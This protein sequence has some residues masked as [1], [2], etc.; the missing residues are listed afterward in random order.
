VA[1]GEQ[2]R[3]LRLAGAG[4][5]LGEVVERD[6]ERLQLRGAFTG[7]GSGS[8]PAAR[9]RLAAA[10]RATGRTIRRARKKAAAAASRPPTS[11]A[12]TIASTNGVHR[13]VVRLFG[14]RRMK[15]RRPTGS[16]A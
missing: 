5:L 1:D 15:A 8:S 11:A 10:T 7:T 12:I 9:L 13:G 16:A 2:E 3:P 14:R 4:Q 6:R